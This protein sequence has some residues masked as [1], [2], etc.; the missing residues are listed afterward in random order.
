M[1]KINCTLPFADILS[2]EREDSCEESP[3]PFV[4]VIEFG[5]ASTVYFFSYRRLYL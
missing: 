5:L 2:I 1:T 4:I 3:N